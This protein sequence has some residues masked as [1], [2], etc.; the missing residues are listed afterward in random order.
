MTQTHKVV[1]HDQWIEARKGLREPV[2]NFGTQAPGL[3]DREGASV[4]AKDE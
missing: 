1:S 2:F 4:F 3:Q